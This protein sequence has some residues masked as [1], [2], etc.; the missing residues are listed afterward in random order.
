MH[1]DE[2]GSRARTTAAVR[3]YNNSTI[4]GVFTLASDP[5]DDVVG[6]VAVI[7]H[8]AIP[9]GF[10]NASAAAATLSQLPGGSVTYVYA[11]MKADPALADDLAD[12]LAPHV[13]LL[14]HRELLRVA[15]MRAA[16]DS[17]RHGPGSPAP[18]AAAHRRR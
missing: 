16:G 3:M 11:N 1:W 12:A 9:W 14:G 13:V 2:D 7:N 18:H 4:R 8:P 6:D 17:P 10:T 15:R 5:I